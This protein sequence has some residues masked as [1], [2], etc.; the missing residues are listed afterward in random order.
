MKLWY[1]SL[2]EYCNTGTS[3]FI[4]AISA[5]YKTLS[6]SGWYTI[7]EIIEKWPVSDSPF[8]IASTSSWLATPRNASHSLFSVSILENQNFCQK[9]L[10]TCLG[11]SEAFRQCPAVRIH[12]LLNNEPVHWC[13]FLT[14]KEAIQGNCWI[15][16]FSPPWILA[17]KFWF[18]SGDGKTPT[19]A[20]ERIFP[21]GNRWVAST[22]IGLLEFIYD[23]RMLR[24]DFKHILWSRSL[25]GWFENGL[26]TL[27]RII[28][29]ESTISYSL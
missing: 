23:I 5:R 27:L 13:A 8:R 16:P 26:K 1:T 7:P 21:A 18:E 20:A 19:W 17:W 12:W 25:I 4:N 10:E 15:K 11:Y 14:C 2:P 29:Y 9:C 28:A 6:Q 22:F 3:I 24:Q